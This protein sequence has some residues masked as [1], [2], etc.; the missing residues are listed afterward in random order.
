M[1]QN[2][3]NTVPQGREAMR[4]GIYARFSS[5]LQKKTSIEDQI[6]NCRDFAAK[7]GWTIVEDFVIADEGISGTS[8]ANRQLNKFID[9]AK[10]RPRPLDGILIDDTSRFGRKLT[11]VLT[12]FEQ[13]T[14]DG[15][16][17]YFVSQGLDSRDKQSWISLAVNG[18]IDQQYIIGLAEKVHRG[19]KG[20]VLRGFNPGGRCYGY[21][22]IE[23]PDPTRIAEHGRAA[24]LGVKL[25]IHEEQACVVLR[26]F[27]MYA[28]G[29]TLAGI[30][31]QLNLEGI[32]APRRRGWCHSGIRLMLR[33]ERYR[34]VVVWN[35]TMNT[36]SPE[37][38][39]GVRRRPQADHV[40]KE[41]PE[42]RIVPEELWR[43]VQARIVFNARFGPQRLGGYNRTANSKRYLFSGK[44]KCGTCGTNLVVIDGQG[45]YAC[46]M[47]RRLG[48]CSNSLSIVNEKLE[49]QLLSALAT[50]LCRTDLLEHAVQRFEEELTLRI[51]ELEK[52]RSA[53]DETAWREELEAVTAKAMNLADAIGRHGLSSILSA[54]LAQS[55]ARIDTINSILKAPRCAAKIPSKEQLRS[56][57]LE[58]TQR[59][60]ET[61][62]GE[63][64]QETKR[65]IQKYVQNLILTPV[66]TSDGPAFQVTGDVD[67]FADGSGVMPDSSCS[68]T[69][70]HHE[71]LLVSLSGIRVHA[72]LRWCNETGFPKL[73][74]AVWNIKSK[75]LR[76]FF[77]F[78][79]TLRRRLTSPNSAEFFVCRITV[80]TT[81]APDRSLAECF[82]NG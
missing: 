21:R 41:H 77:K 80:L 62:D 23:I 18:I 75:T 52:S 72:R 14:F 16:F 22:N 29:W 53:M 81:I 67:L 50:N 36:R 11:D 46:P 44:L 5:D 65:V 15:V 12:V 10:S 2:G 1:S 17:L 24:T 78:A 20:V 8:V 19:Q 48:K 35:R 37:G 47:H 70:K 54:Q 56:F 25:E 4:C 66:V 30:A 45:R 26:V 71:S 33:N 64:R 7:M 76:V 13:L 57:V 9:A 55:E 42:L 40:R 27:Q 74:G 60:R 58:K 28:N 31:S 49:A 32:R 68:G 34:G 38:K 79:S 73:F 39:P 82:S 59:L 61:L 69:D 63:D 43:D 51:R 6:R 3:P